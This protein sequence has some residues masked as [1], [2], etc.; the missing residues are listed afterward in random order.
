MTDSRDIGRLRRAPASRG[1]CA[2]A[3]GAPL[4]TAMR[5]GYV[6]KAQLGLASV[7]RPLASSLST[8]SPTEL[9]F[10]CLIRGSSR[11]RT[12]SANQ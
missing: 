8:I 7:L 4:S 2:G 11:A 5:R 10:S 1:R 9:V 6:L 3:A 12:R